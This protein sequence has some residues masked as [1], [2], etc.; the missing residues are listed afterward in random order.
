M[1][2]LTCDRIGA[3]PQSGGDYDL[4]RGM[5]RCYVANSVRLNSR[6]PYATVCGS[7]WLVA[8]HISG[9]V[10]GSRRKLS[11]RRMWTARSRRARTPIVGFIMCISGCPVFGGPICVWIHQGSCST[12]GRSRTMS[13][14]SIGMGGKCMC[15]CSYGFGKLRAGVL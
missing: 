5:V 6:M 11:A 15:M 13:C 14:V 4:S 7:A 9:N 8:G 12:V 1:H 10:C 3:V 2:C